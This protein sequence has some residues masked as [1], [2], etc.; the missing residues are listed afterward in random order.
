MAYWFENDRKLPSGK[1]TA[2]SWTIVGLTLVM[3]SGYWKLQVI[4]AQRYQEMADRN[5]IRSMPIAAPRGRMFDRNG[6]KLVDNYPGFA[7]LLLRDDAKEVDRHLPAIAEGL[8]LD[9][10][11]LQ[12][13][14]E[15]SRDAADYKPL[16]LKD[17]TASDI[18]FVEAHR[19][20]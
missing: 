17:A 15:E 9:V 3:L 7:V 5:R 8:G 4:D 12:R 16:E 10:A 13:R 11:D 20:D 6:F 19:L 18:A 14:L 1:L 2:V